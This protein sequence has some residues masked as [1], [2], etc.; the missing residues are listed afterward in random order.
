MRASFT[1]TLVFGLVAVEIKAF[2]TTQAQ[3]LH[4]TTLHR[5]C[6]APVKVTHICKLCERPVP[7]E[8][9]TKGIETPNG[10]VTFDEQEL[11][12][13]DPITPEGRPIRGEQCFPV[14]SLNPLWYDQAYFLVP[15]AVE[16]MRPYALIKRVLREEKLCVAVTYTTRGH[17]HLGVVV[18]FDDGLLLRRLFYANELQS[19]ADYHV[20]MGPV[21]L[22]NKEITLAKR[23]FKMMTRSFKHETYQ[24]LGHL[25][26]VEALHA[27]EKKLPMPAPIR[28]DPMPPRV[29]SLL[30]ALTQSVAKK[31]KT[32]PQPKRMAR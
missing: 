13:L 19:M 14:A 22:S 6:L 5:G 2:Q 24:D 29:I 17:L 20:G 16:G 23:L 4:F 7:K 32:I 31:Q 8:D 9:S 26:F 25:R 12:R 15:A 27:K 30:E 18:P 1:G 10:W 11:D 21:D 3:D 28:R